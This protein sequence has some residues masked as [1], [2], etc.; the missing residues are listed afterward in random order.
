MPEAALCARF[1]K[2][3]ELIGRR[4]SGAIIQMLFRRPAR[5]AELR[6]VIPDITDRM[7]SERL[8]E[9]EEEGL[10][11]RTVIPQTPVRVE[12]QLSAKGRALEPALAAIGKWAE[13]WVTEL[14]AAAG[15]TVTK[16]VRPR[17][18]R[19]QAPTRA[20]ARRVRGTA[21]DCPRHAGGSRCSMARPGSSDSYMVVV[22]GEAVTRVSDRRVARMWD[23]WMIERGGRL[24][25]DSENW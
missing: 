18:A 25:W 21:P 6:S 11:V 14:P 7:L 12:Y 24:Q 19:R 4:W 1:H 5:F 20:S 15:E 16:A 13:H 3:I 8:Q 23:H 22:A 10:V 17:P 9:L 2:A